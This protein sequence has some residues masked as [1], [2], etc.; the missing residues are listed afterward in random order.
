[1]SDLKT[2]LITIG[3]CIPFLAVIAFVAFGADVGLT[4]ASSFAE[5]TFLATLLLLAAVL[6]AVFYFTPALTA[7]IVK[8]EHA[9]A[10]TVLNLFLGGMPV[11][12]VAALCWA[13]VSPRK[14]EGGVA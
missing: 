2:P 9:T 14:T 8:A 3:V 5:K 6:V 12:W 11:V 4:D 7:F 10:I 1:M 13:L